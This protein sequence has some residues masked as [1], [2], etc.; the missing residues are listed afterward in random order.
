L[1][2]KQK[3]NNLVFFL[4]LYQG[5]EKF[6]RA[7]EAIFYFFNGNAYAAPPSSVPILSKNKTVCAYMSYLLRLHFD[8]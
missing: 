2:T 4:K 1:K 7:A 8:L 6:L 5:E 3:K